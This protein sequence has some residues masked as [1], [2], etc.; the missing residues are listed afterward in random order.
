MTPATDFQPTLKFDVTNALELW[1]AGVEG[2]FYFIL[3]VP[4]VTVQMPT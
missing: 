1:D 2:L 4:V 3:G